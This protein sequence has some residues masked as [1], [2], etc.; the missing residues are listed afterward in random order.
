MKKGFK[1]VTILR[2]PIDQFY[3][4]FYYAKIDR[5]YRL[6][7]FTDPIAHFFN[8]T[9][10]YY[11]KGISRKSQGMSE[12]ELL[13]KNGMSFDLNY[14]L[15]Q[16]SSR[17]ATFKTFLNFLDKSFHLV[18]ITELFNES[19]ILLKKMMCWSYMDI[20]YQKKLVNISLRTKNISRF[21]KEKFKNWN[22][23]DIQLYAYFKE[24]LQDILK[25]QDQVTFQDDLVKFRELNS[26]VENY[27]KKK[28]AEQYHK[29]LDYLDEINE[30]PPEEFTNRPYCFCAKLNRSEK[31]YVEYFRRKFPVFY[32]NSRLSAMPREMHGC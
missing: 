5:F 23:L 16:F 9:K 22:Y 18:M 29:V 8:N 10:A 24:K 19:L 6:K 11:N 12:F 1:M 3:S 20:V 13:L 26:L 25:R 32:F 14:L 31:Q 17:N 28:H 2:N 30:D 4:L 27:C 7:N 21:V 15:I